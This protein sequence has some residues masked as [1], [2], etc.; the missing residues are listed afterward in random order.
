MKRITI[1][2]VAA[3]LAA[4][5]AAFIASTGGAA[6][7]PKAKTG[8]FRQVLASKLGAQLH[9]PSED[10]LTALKAAA[11]S[12]SERQARVEARRN[13][14]KP[15]KTDRAKR[16][17][18]WTASMAESLGVEPSAVTAAVQALV[19]QRLDSLVEDGWLTPDQAAKRAG[20]LGIGFLRVGGR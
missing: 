12:K 9:K 2:G 20:K 7:A 19:K 8:T 10:V 5:L 13:G 18:A 3:I 1:A 4:A 16:K 17:E 11:P 6:A 14:S 15:S